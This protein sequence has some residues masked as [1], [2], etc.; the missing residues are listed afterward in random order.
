[1][2]KNVNHIQ[3]EVLGKLVLTNN[4]LIFNPSSLTSLFSGGQEVIMP[5]SDIV[6]IGTKQTLFGLSKHI[7]VQLKEGR[8]ENF[9]FRGTDELVD[10]VK[11]QMSSQRGG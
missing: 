10:A 9:G 5:L 6:D 2:E 8:E 3:Q 7:W 11:K 1:M 4:S